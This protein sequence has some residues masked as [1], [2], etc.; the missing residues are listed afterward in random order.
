MALKKSQRSLRAWTKQKWRTKS[1]K[2]SSETGERYLPEAAIKALSPAEYAATTRKKRKDTKKGKQHSKQP[3]RIAK[4]TR[5]A[6]QFKFMGGLSEAEK[7]PITEI[8]STLK[9]QNIN[10]IP[11][12]A[13]N[14]ITKKQKIMSRLFKMSAA[15][16]AR[17]FVAPTRLNLNKEDNEI[18]INIEKKYYNNPEAFRHIILEELKHVP[19]IRNEKLYT[20][21][22]IPKDI[23]ED[24][25]RRVPIQI[26]DKAIYS[27]PQPMQDNLLADMYSKEETRSLKGNILRKIND[28]FMDIRKPRYSTPGMLEYETHNIPDEEI[29]KQFGLEK[30]RQFKFI[31]GKVDITEIEKQ[32]KELVEPLKGLDSYVIDDIRTAQ[33]SYKV[34]ESTIKKEKENNALDKENWQKLDVPTFPI[35]SLEDWAK[36]RNITTEEL[37]RLKKES[38]LELYSQ[39][40]KRND[41]DAKFGKNPELSQTPFT[42]TEI[43]RLGRENMPKNVRTYVD[44]DLREKLTNKNVLA[45]YGASGEYPPGDFVFPVGDKITEAHEV[46]HIGFDKVPGLT[47]HLKKKFGYGN[48]EHTYIIEKTEPEFFD[49]DMPPPK[50]FTEEQ[51]TEYIKSIASNASD[52][53]YRK[54]V[55]R[56]VEKYIKENNLN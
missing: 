30:T 26:F 21:F 27:L 19:H 51:R 29:A 9:K 49:L 35:N 54:K 3:K 41:P 25:V 48:H 17:S 52:K 34:F 22:K 33:E 14:P 39:Q 40:R 18:D 37:Q 43:E 6:R 55:V 46:M 36:F 4:K 31:G 38:D 45:P 16:P 53:R 28:K 50:G 56:E 8:I 10:V 20:Y 24:T 1:G 47:E 5:R 11:Y 23:I 12:D 15:E 2:K 7:T 44:F 42:D 32:S 13:D